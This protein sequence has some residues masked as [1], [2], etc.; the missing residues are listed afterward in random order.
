[1]TRRRS[2]LVTLATTL[3]L[4]L[5]ASSASAQEPDGHDHHQRPPEYDDPTLAVPPVSGAPS[6]YP[7]A[8]GFTPA[9]SSNYTLDGM[10]TV[11]Y[12]VVHT[13]QGSYAGS[14][15]WF[16]NPA[17]NVSAHYCM[18]SSDG[19]VTQMVHHEDRAWHVGNSNSVSLGIEHEGFVDDPDWYTWLMYLESARL[20]RWL[21]DSH[22]LPLDRDHIVGHVELPNQTHTDPGPNWDWDLYMALIHDVVPQ[23]EIRGVVVDRSRACTVTANTDTWL[24]ATPEPSDALADDQ[25]CSVP[26]GTELVVLHDEGDFIGH[27]RLVLDDGSP[28]AAEL[29]GWGYAFAGHFDG[30]C[31]PFD[32]AAVGAQVSLAGGAAIEVDAEGRFG[33]T[34]LPEGD[35]ALDVTGDGYEF[36]TASVALEVYPGARVVIGVDPVPDPGGD[37]TSGGLDD[38]GGDSTGGEPGTTGGAE[39]T[40]PPGGTAGSDDGYDPALPPGL[41]EGDEG[42]GCRGQGGPGRTGAIA[43]GVLG[44]LGLRRRRGL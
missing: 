17:S 12:V 9:H 42:C 15:S 5:A 1:M 13:M 2:T 10:G 6:E 23:G 29:A 4:A 24:K 35:H 31:D 44:L 20:A 39:D 27:R 11:Q 19:E 22:G 3:T 32:A 25:R 38:S 30:A 8:V 40:G 18:R 36:A 26:A 33:F 16:Q 21:A 43:L 28:C 34:G 37:D 14:I 41:G 7:R